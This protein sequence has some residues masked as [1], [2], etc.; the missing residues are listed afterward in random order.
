MGE[1]FTLVGNDANA[2][3][4]NPAGIALSEDQYNFVLNRTDW[5]ADIAYNA[6]AVTATFGSIGTFGVSLLAADYPMSMGT[7]V[8]NNEQGYVETGEFSG[9]AMSFG[10][11]YARSFTNAFTF[12]A[13]VSYA[14]QNLGENMVPVLQSGVITDSTKTENDVNGLSYDVGT[15]FYPGYK[16]FRFGMSITNYSAQFEYEED[17]FQ[18]PLTFSF[19][20]AMDILDLWGEHPDMSLVVDLEAIHPRDAGQRIHAGGE[21]WYQNMFALRA[22]YKFNYD[23]ESFSAGVGF[24]MAGAIID[25][26]YT[27]F[28]IFTSVQRFSVGYAF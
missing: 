12:G 18:L 7:R 27:R 28:G 6:A 5:I 10:A 22:G 2:M 15:I 26:A 4:Y 8:A 3:F 21:F 25:Y 16:S 24:K 9:S 20:A 11:G 13:K 17:P 14:L 1:A 23:E 19:G